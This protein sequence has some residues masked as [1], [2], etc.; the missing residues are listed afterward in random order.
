MSL[1]CI[2]YNWIIL[3]IKHID[4]CYFLHGYKVR[5]VNGEVKAQIVNKDT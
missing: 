1:H 3:I 2:N 5:V 4:S